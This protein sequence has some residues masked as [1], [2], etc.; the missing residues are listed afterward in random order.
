MEKTW[1]KK[2]KSRPTFLKI[3]EMLLEHIDKKPFLYLSYYNRWKNET[4]AAADVEVAIEDDDEGNDESLIPLKALSNNTD[5]SDSDTDSNGGS[6]AGQL[7]DED[8]N[9]N[10]FPLSR[11]V[12]SAVKLF[13]EDGEEPA[14]NEREQGNREEADDSRQTKEPA[15]KSVSLIRLNELQNNGPDKRPPSNLL[16]N[17]LSASLANSESLSSSSTSNVNVEGSTPN[18]TEPVMKPVF[19]DFDASKLA[20]SKET[21]MNAPSR[22]LINGHLINTSMV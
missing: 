6:S 12:A 16:N 13:N 5:E 7:S 1:E 20:Q 15:D 21:A 3:V 2:P 14:D 17:N 9:F 22:N 19:G 10:F 11:N 18:A 4:N 8:M